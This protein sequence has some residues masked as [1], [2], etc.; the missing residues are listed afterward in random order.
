MGDEST[1]TAERQKAAAF[2]AQNPLTNNSLLTTEQHNIIIVLMIPPFTRT[3]YLPSGI[4]PAI[5]Q[6]FVDRFGWNDHRRELIGGLWIAVDGL[7]EA[8]CRV[9]YV[10]GSF[11]T[12]IAIPNDFDACW[13]PTD[14]DIPLLA[15]LLP[16]LFDFANKRA[17]QKARFRGELFPAFSPANAGGQPFLEFFQFDR[18]GRPKGIVMLDLRSWEL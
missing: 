8:G 10:D 17:A 6:E 11:A 12:A 14:V 13:D 15:D 7:H 1:A 9:V 3:G 16:D 18:D 5:W 4:H 2:T